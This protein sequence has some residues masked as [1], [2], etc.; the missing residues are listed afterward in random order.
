MD[1]EQEIERQSCKPE[2]LGKKVND[3]LSAERRVHFEGWSG[4][5]FLGSQRDMVWQRLVQ[6]KQQWQAPGTAGLPNSSGSGDKT[7]HQ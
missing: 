3:E 7:Y 6:H 1:Y 4:R 2:T 5:I